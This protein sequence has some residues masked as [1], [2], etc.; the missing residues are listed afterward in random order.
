MITLA[1]YFTALGY[2]IVSCPVL[3]LLA[4]FPPTFLSS[5][6]HYS[7]LNFALGLSG[8]LLLISKTIQYGFYIFILVTR[9]FLSSM[10]PQ[11]SARATVQRSQQDHGLQINRNTSSGIERIPLEHSYAEQ[12][13]QSALAVEGL[14]IA[15]AE[16]ASVPE[17]QAVVK[18]AL[19]VENVAATPSKRVQIRIY[20]GLLVLAIIIVI[21]A[22]VTTLKSRTNRSK[23]GSNEEATAAATSGP[24]LSASPGPP[25]SSPGIPRSTSGA[26]NGTGLCVLRGD[27]VQIALFYQHYTGAIRVSRLPWN[28]AWLPYDSTQDLLVASGTRNGTPMATVGYGISG[29]FAVT[30][31]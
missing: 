1:E 17:K 20:A 6:K 31:L 11:P 15:Y 22:V 29:T 9:T 2:R 12:L 25:N 18:S 10:E 14:E 26:Y 16:L 5:F 28:G 30:M 21:V 3:F 23:L 13:P 8:C 4:V 7:T 24:T 27:S 19:R